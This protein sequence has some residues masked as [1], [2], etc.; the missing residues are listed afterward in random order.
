MN[1]T[2]WKDH[3]Y[4]TSA[5][6]PGTAGWDWFSLQFEDKTALMVYVLRGEDGTPL[7]FSKGTFLDKDGSITHLNSDDWQLNISKSWKSP[8]SQATYPAGWTLSIPKLSLE[9][10]GEPFINNQEL[11]LSTTYWEGAVKFKGIRQSKPLSA[12]GYVELTGYKES[13]TSLR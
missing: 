13:L 10:N 6:S 12:K 5:L 4:S 9:I 1:G 8:T 3:E 7:E 2:S 11:N